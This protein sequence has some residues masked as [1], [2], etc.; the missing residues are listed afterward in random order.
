MSDKN[1]SGDS[2]GRI[3]SKRDGEK[4]IQVDITAHPTNSTT[5]KNAKHLC[6]AGR[7]LLLETSSENQQIK[8]DELLSQALNC[9]QE[10]EV[11]DPDY[12]EASVNSAY[13]LLLQQQWENARE[14]AIC[15]CSKNSEP[16]AFAKASLILARVYVRENSEDYERIIQ[17]LQEAC[18]R[19]PTHSASWVSLFR[20]L[21]KASTPQQEIRE[22]MS[23]KF[24]DAQFCGKVR[25]EL[26]RNERELLNENYPELS[27]IIF[28][29]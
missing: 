2:L 15:I 20:Q 5:N 1:C 29:H 14:K 18:R 8:K 3:S 24:D 23:S 25:R 28:E 10:A 7:N 4:S 9:F 17:V 12:W 26:S 6:D 19:C 11:I 13:V 22:I 27:L 21:L 16:L